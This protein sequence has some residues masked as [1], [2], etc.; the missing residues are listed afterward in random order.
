M[1]NIDLKGLEFSWRQL[2][3]EEASSVCLTK[4]SALSLQLRKLQETKSQNTEQFGDRDLK[5]S[6]TQAIETEILPRLLMSYDMQP[7]YLEQENLLDWVPSEETVRDFTALLLDDDFDASRSFVDELLTEGV[8]IESLYL[9]LFTGSARLLGSY[10]EDDVSSFAEVT[11]GLGRLQQMLRKFSPTFGEASVV[12]DPAKRV[13]AVA[14]AGEQHL[15]GI[16]M[17]Q[18]FF[19]RAGWFVPPVTEFDM[20][21]T[22]PLVRDNWFSVVGFSL[23]SEVLL[24]DLAVSIREVRKQS[25]NESVKIFVGGSIFLNN[26]ELVKDLGAD[27][28][29]VDGKQAVIR[30]EEIIA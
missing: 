4:T 20:Q 12:M 3:D 10:W 8:S 15:F 2:I 6:L 7:Q 14:A 16:L 1:S 19:R 23:S 26:N 28:M 22:I 13:L 9:N 30:A 29:A 5:D 25:N 27:A 18:E 17:V 21:D 11:I 24:E